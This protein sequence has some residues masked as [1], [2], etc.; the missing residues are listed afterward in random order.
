MNILTSNLLLLLAA[1]IWGLAF[2]A[3]RVGM[4]YVGPFTFNGVRFALGSLSLVP[5]ILFYKNS[6]PTQEKVE[7]GTKNVVV[8]GLWAGLVLFIAASLQQIGLLYTTAGKAAF[9]TCLYIVLVPILG[10]FLKQYVSMST[11][12]GSVIAVVGLYL[13]CVRDSFFISYGEV[14]ELV[15]AF[16]WAIHILLIDHFSRRVPV[17]KLACFQFITCSILS[18][19]T[20]LFIETISIHKIYQ[21][22]IPI[23]Y[24]GIC[25]VGIAYT[26]QVVAQKNAQPSHAA[27]ILSMET[28][29]AAIGGWLILNEKLGFQESLGCVIMFIGM[30]LSQLQNLKK[31]EE[32]ADNLVVNS[33]SSGNME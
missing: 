3:Q 18:L 17:L 10:I 12:I 32:S 9:I 7:H 6:S 22:A 15:G 26:L 5:L 4:E 8:A 16:F 1:A 27:I 29:F 19:V 33:S 28:V 23:L 24:G 2:V 14:L 21:A 13:L 31:P 20:A 30:L 11:W 25:S